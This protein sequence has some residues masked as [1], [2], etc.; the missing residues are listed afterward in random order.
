MSSSA[1]DY[2]PPSQVRYW[3]ED[4]ESQW[5]LAQEEQHRAARPT[6]TTSPAGRGSYALT[7]ALARDVAERFTAHAILEG[8]TAKRWG[9][10]P[11]GGG[12][13]ALID[14]AQR[15][16]IGRGGNTEARHAARLIVSAGRTR[17][18]V[19][20]NSVAHDSEQVGFGHGSARLHAGLIR[21]GLQTEPSAH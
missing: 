14:P 19:G 8:K 5:R 4:H 13:A 17:P 11:G 2:L 7:F 16:L 12:R 15:P 6:G 1:I 10:N 3:P 18:A 20:S 9:G 21:V